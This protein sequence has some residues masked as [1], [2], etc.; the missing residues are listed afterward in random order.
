MNGEEQYMLY[1]AIKKL[2][3]EK[4]VL[5]D[6]L[7]IAI[8]GLEVLKSDGNIIGIPQKTLDEIK[9]QD[10]ELPQDKSNVKQD[11]ID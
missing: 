11:K 6:K 3:K 8:E 5:E 9:L 1:E 4:K 2:E 10:E 7:S